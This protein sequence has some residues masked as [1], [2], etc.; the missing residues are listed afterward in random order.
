[1]QTTTMAETGQ[2]RR[3]LHSAW[4]VAV[5]FMQAVLFATIARVGPKFRAIFAEMLPGEPL[6]LLT[7]WCLRLTPTV[8]V[9]ALVLVL[10]GLFLKEYQLRDSGLARRLNIAAVVLAVVAFHVYLVGL[11]LP[12]VHLI[13]HVGR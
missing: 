13:D 1:M 11:F 9:T 10:A 3:G 7:V 8:S 4:F 5:V 12:L 2:T 6:P